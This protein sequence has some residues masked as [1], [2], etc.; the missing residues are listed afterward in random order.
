MAMAYRICL[1]FG[2]AS[3]L[4]ATIVAA[5][6]Q[7]PDV[8]ASPPAA[9]A[10][11]P[12]PT[13]SSRCSAEGRAATLDCIVSQRLFVKNTGQRIGSVT[14]RMPGDRENPV[15]V[16]QIPTGLLLPAGVSIDIDGKDQQQLELETC[17]G[18]SCYVRQP[19][20]DSLLASMVRGQT[21]NIS[22]QNLNKQKIKLPLSLVGFTAAYNKIK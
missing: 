19:V 16:I 13:W 11:A 10:T 8:T 20:S 1:R 9:R 14:I 22:F 6:A 18:N 2:I 3:L 17:D 5:K 15:M 12:T 7:Q 21:L 4:L